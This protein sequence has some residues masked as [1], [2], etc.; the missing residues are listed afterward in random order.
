MNLFRHLGR[1]AILFALF[2]THSASAAT[3]DTGWLDAADA[4]KRAEKPA[5]H[6][7]VE[8]VAEKTTL[9]PQGVNRLAV[10]FTHDEGWH[11]YWKMPGDAG[12]P[13]R[14]SFTLPKDLKASEPAFPLPHRSRAAGIESF[15]YDGV[16]LFPFTVDV[17]RF[18]GIQRAEV[19]V[20]VEYLACRDMCVPETA[21]ASIRLPIAVNGKDSD[22]AEAVRAAL[23]L[24][25][26]TVPADRARLT[27]VMEENRIRID[28]AAEA[29]AP[30]A[31]DFY[32]TQPD[33]LSLAHAPRAEFRR[34]PEE[35]LPAGASIYLTADALFAQK[36][37]ESIRGVLVAEGGPEKGGWAIE[38]EVPLEKGAVKT[39]PRAPEPQ[40]T[41][42]A[43]AAAPQGAS[44]PASALFAFLGGLILNL[45]PCVFPVLS[46]KL[47]QLVEGAQ[48]GGRLWTHGIAFTAGVLVTMLALSGTLL[49][50]RSAGGAVGWGFQLQSPAVVA[51]LML[52]FAAIVFNL[53]GLFEF[54]W[55]ATAADSRLARRAPTTGVGG[56]FATGILAVVVAS[57]CT[58]PFMGAALGYALT[59]PAAEALL[60]FAAL[61][62]G[63]AFPWLLLTVVPFW[64]KKL[65]K[66]GPWMEVFRRVMAVPMAAAVLWL[67][68][69]LSKQVELLGLVAVVCAVSALGVLLWQMGRR[70]WG[71]SASRALMAVMAAVS[72]LG[73]AAAGSGAF[74]RQAEASAPAADGWQRWSPK[75]LEEA[76]A[77]GRPVFVDFTAAWCVTCQANKLTALHRAEVERAMD[78]RGYVKLVA[79]WTNRNAEIAEVLAQFGR[80]GV[81]LYLIYR[82][83][84]RVDV[85]PELLTAEIVLDA[86]RAP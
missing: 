22:D 64:A 5:P 30:R 17:P 11:T 82:P 79:D 40:P 34:A 68:W 76:R 63:M 29:F 21:V 10:R 18:P 85:L 45:M 46:L 31:L 39:A 58:A 38:T 56:S 57:P 33:V 70:Q 37:A 43:P 81:P 14:F 53:L 28:L 52:L 9:T 55:G 15:V 48:K 36:P 26:E 49:A 4:A 47:L 72:L 6:V 78:E 1:A 50:L 59:Q 20:R 54:T 51:L 42:A 71:L 75:T 8:L 19:K 13:P 23:S 27:A 61:G 25:P 74:D 41:G 65:P 66:P 35:G 3:S 86:V 24:V 2:L 7:K 44:I 83:D 84:G 62:F 60:V 69:V 32:P 12:L 73:V 77:S 16:T 67:G 80:S